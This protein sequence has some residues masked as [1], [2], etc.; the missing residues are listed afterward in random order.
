MEAKNQRT[1]KTPLAQKKPPEK[2]FRSMEEIRKHFFPNFYEEEERRNRTPE[3]AALRLNK[4][5]L[6][7][8]SEADFVNELDVSNLNCH[9]CPTG[10]RNR[11]F[12]HVEA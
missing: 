7:N 5:H 3:T 9:L 11:V 2:V 10:R 8:K 4:R 6:W 12:S 1:P